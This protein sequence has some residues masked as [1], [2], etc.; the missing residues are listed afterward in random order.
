MIYSGVSLFPDQLSRAESVEA[1]HDR[2][3]DIFDENQIDAEVGW[4]HKISIFA[5]LTTYITYIRVVQDPK[6][7]FFGPGPDF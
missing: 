2:I 3:G 4:Q 1:A 5:Q 7:Y 6:I